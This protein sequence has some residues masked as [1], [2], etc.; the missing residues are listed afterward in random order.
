[1]AQPTGRASRRSQRERKPREERWTELL[2]VATRVFY[3]KGYE[4]ASLRDIADRMGM[5][6]GSLYYYIESKDDLLFEVIT[7]VHQ[8][9]LDVIRPLASGTGSPL[10]RLERVVRGH[11]EHTCHNL[12]STTVFLHELGVLSKERQRIVL[13]EHSYQDVFRG[14]IAEALDAGE[15]RSEVDPRLAALSILGSA[16]W[17]YRWFRPDGRDSAHTVGAKFADMAV[18]GIASDA[19][20]R[21][22]TGAAGQLEP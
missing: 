21:A 8:R 2:E 18:R 13:G 15:V 3:E 4:A 9:G 6:K 11:V 17:V 7:A 12:I 22:L 5:L 19:G 14:L 16:N 10:V 20:S 1:M